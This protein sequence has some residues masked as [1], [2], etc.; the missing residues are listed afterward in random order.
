MKWHSVNV[1]IHPV[2]GGVAI[3]SHWR[4]AA[5]LGCKYALNFRSILWLIVN[6]TPENAGFMKQNITGRAVMW[7][8]IGASTA[9]A[10]GRMI[11][12]SSGLFDYLLVGMT[13]GF[14]MF[15]CF[16]VGALSGT[17]AN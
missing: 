3:M 15:V 10:Y 13:G 8:T 4:Q 9:L 11:D 6:V 14:V 7:A 1:W 16:V 2:P 12:G 5:E 17:D